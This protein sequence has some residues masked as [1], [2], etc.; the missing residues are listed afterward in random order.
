MIVKK[1]LLTVFLPLLLFESTFAQK[2]DSANVR[3]FEAQW[4]Y[5]N[6]YSDSN[7]SILLKPTSFMFLKSLLLTSLIFDKRPQ[8][9]HIEKR[10][11]FKYH[12]DAILN[13]NI[14][15]VPKVTSQYNPATN[16][17]ERVVRTDPIKLFTKE[18]ITSLPI[19]NYFL[20]TSE[21]FDVLQILWSQGDVPDTKIYQSLDPTTI[22]TM[23]DLNK[24][25]EAMQY[26]QLISRKRISPENIFSFVA[27]GIYVG[28][29]EQSPE[30]IKNKLFLNH[31]N[32]DEE[33][34]KRFISAFA[35]T[36]EEDSSI[37]NQKEFYAAR[38]DSTLIGDLMAKISK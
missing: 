24:L 27:F 9:I 16:S 19:K 3:K 32:V 7:K 18:Q 5:E 38:F 28:G 33:R 13:L 10:S 6:I 23:K 31:S 29:F 37:I 15:S 21:E 14:K 20:P 22:Q 1:R 12:A 2:V 8:R 26:K 34:M 36:Y 11:D 17:Y 4:L 25:L 35:Y 30:N